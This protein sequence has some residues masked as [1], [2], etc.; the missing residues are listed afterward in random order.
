MSLNIR[1]RFRE[2]KFSYKYKK[3]I[4]KDKELEQTKNK[5]TKENNAKIAIFSPLV[6]VG[7]I[8]KFINHFFEQ[9]ET[10]ENEKELYSDN[11][12]TT[13]IN[14]SLYPKNTKINSNSINRHKIAKIAAQPNLDSQKLEK[15]KKNYNSG[16]NNQIP[17]DNRKKKLVQYKFLE[18]EKNR[19]NNQ[20]KL[21]K[22]NK[23]V[24]KKGSSKE[25][26]K[27]AGN[28]PVNS[29][30][31]NLENKIFSKFKKILEKMDNEFLDIKSEAYLTNKYSN[32]EELLKEAIIIEQKIQHLV[33]R[34][35]E[36]KKQY[37][38]I[39]EEKFIEDPSIL[40]DSLLIDD[41]YNYRETI[42][43][44]DQNIIP[45]KLKLLDEYCHLF[46]NL[47]KLENNI[48]YIKSIRNER[49]KE[50]SKRD[51]EIKNKKQ[52]IQHLNEISEN[53][54][55]IINKHN[56]Y[57][58]EISNKVQQIDQKKFI[59]H[60]LKGLNG[61]LSTSLKYIGLVGLSPLRGLI[62]SIAE[63]TIATRKLISGMIKNIHYEKNEKI[64][65]SVH[66]YITEI[67]NKIYDINNVNKNIDNAFYDVQRLKNE[68]KDYYLKYHLKE[69]EEVY[70]KIE[71]I[72]EDIIKNKKKIA[73]IK[74]NLI[75]SKD[76]NKNVLK[77]VRKLNN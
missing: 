24:Q 17:L 9:Q 66:N 36:I 3:K 13:A 74:N 21:N 31:I 71:K 12:K 34:L 62:P 56:K 27:S 64:V 61:L 7:Y 60:K 68:F 32:D 54:N 23:N 45:E 8:R 75:K 53:C 39:D 40:D 37:T 73:S 38:I 19:N 42:N 33:D 65:Y 59:N 67:D 52:K 35:D 50:L 77:K 26:S 47:E 70:K 5:E 51:N 4:E 22:K 69:Y 48:T 14:N 11:K 46:I 6:I 2:R 20:D 58:E 28:T 41:I 1:E 25:E 63:K 16:M 44:N 57:L 15:Q 72:E 10:I 76:E 43:I 18:D 30:S 29:N 55:S 49:V